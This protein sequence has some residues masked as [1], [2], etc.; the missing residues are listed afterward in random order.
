MEGTM[1]RV[2]PRLMREEALPGGGDFG[3]SLMALW[4]DSGASG[5]FR[6]GPSLD[7]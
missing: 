5:V 6:G 7:N 2:V 4:R 1:E 3:V